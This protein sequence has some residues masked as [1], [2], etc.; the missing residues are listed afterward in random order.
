[1][2]D[3]F[4]H[5][6]L[7]LRTIED[8]G[9]VTQNDEM[10]GWAVIFLLAPPSPSR[11]QRTHVAG[12][13]CLLRKPVASNNSIGFGVFLRRYVTE[14]TLAIRLRGENKNTALPPV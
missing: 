5:D 6:F 7:L 9:M 8:I 14:K 4:V 10:I 12:S 3:L 13:C 2:V 11:D 1:M